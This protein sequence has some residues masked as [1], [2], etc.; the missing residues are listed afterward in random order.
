MKTQKT[1]IEEGLLK[2][3]ISIAEMCEDLDFKLKSFTDS[4][5]RDKFS[6]IRCVMISDYL[7]IDLRTLIL[8]PVDKPR[9]PRKIKG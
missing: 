5:H 2:K 3:G 6:A 7:N 4:W 1:L 8:S 9:Q